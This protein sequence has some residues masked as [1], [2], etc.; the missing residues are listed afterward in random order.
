MDKIQQVEY[1]IKQVKKQIVNIQT[2]INN[3]KKKSLDFGEILSFFSREKRRYEADLAAHMSRIKR[4][5]NSLDGTEKFKRKY[6]EDINYMSRSCGVNNAL[7]K[8]SL[9][10]RNAKRERGNS[11]EMLKEKN[12]KLNNLNIRLKEL[13][14]K[15]KELLLSK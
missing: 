11:D 10:E 4:N 8:L 15:K 3:Y 2:E 9:G 6:L 12:R 14:K 1:D 13:E 5:I 7:D